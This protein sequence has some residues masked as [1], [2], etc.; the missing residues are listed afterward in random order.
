MPRAAK[1]QWRNSLRT[2]RKPGI[3][4]S[5]SGSIQRHVT[6]CSMSRIELTSLPIG[7]TGSTLPFESGAETDLASDGGRSRELLIVV[8]RKVVGRHYQ[9]Q[10][11]ISVC[12]PGE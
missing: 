9:A 8:V 6:S 3:S 11:V 7:S 2:M 10:P 12:L 4:A 1:T 5:G